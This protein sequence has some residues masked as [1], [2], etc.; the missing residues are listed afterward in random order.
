[1]PVLKTELGKV[2]VHKIKLENPFDKEVKIITKVINQT[3]F[4][5]L[6]EN[7]VIKPNDFVMAS[8]RYTPSNLDVT[9]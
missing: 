2:D 6:P 1:M 7:I 8:I 3:N 4:D 5:V 9:E